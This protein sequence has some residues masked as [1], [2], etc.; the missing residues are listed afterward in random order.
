MLIM[1]VTVDPM[2]CDLHIVLNLMSALLEEVFLGFSLSLGGQP[3]AF[4]WSFG[5]SRRITYT[6][7][8]PGAGQFEIILTRIVLP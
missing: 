5:G 4:L 6:H 8:G 7:A 3:D 1:V 2:G